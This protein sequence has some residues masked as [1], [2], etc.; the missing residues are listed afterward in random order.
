MEEP[1]VEFNEVVFCY[2]RAEVL[3]GVSF[4]LKKGDVVGLLGPMAPEKA[5]P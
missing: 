3:H 5:R 1:V 4:P 2:D